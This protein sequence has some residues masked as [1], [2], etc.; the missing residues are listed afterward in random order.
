[1][2]FKTQAQFARRAKK[3]L[4]DRGLSV[5]DLAGRID[6]RRDSVSTAIHN[7]RFPKVRARIAKYL[8]L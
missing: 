5:T 4:I 8:G 6:Q 1:M 2:A 7:C 3:A